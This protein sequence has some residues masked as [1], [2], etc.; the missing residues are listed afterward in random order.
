MHLLLRN[1]RHMGDLNTCLLDFATSPIAGHSPDSG[2]TELS[3]FGTLPWRQ[4]NP[5]DDK[6]MFCLWSFCLVCETSRRMK[7]Y[8]T[9]CPV[10]GR[11]GS[12]HFEMR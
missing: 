3:G 2:T 6:C 10:R 4:D 8:A 5:I 9:L 7:K 1:N 11:C 12:F